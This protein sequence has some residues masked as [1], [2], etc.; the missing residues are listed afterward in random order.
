MANKKDEQKNAAGA[1]G[2]QAAAKADTATNETTSPATAAEISKEAAKNETPPANK[3]KPNKKKGASSELRDVDEHIAAKNL[4]RWMG[5]SIK[6]FAGWKS[7]KAVSKEEFKE[8]LDG[9][10]KRSQGGGRR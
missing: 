3:P 6:V 8:A 9:W 5:E 2:S 10:N 7:G 4:P 1:A